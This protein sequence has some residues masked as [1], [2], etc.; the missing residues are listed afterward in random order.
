MKIK[1]IQLHPFAGIQEEKINF[2]DGM[3]L[4]IGPNMAGKSTI[5]YAINHGLLTSSNLTSRQFDN[6]MAP[7][8]PVGGDVIRVTLKVYTVDPDSCFQ[9]QK[10]WKPGLRNGQ[11]KLIKPDGT[12]I[13]DEDKIQKLIESLLPVTPSTMREVMLS[14]QSELHRLM[15][16]MEEHAE[17][18]QELSDVLRQNVMEAGGMSVDKFR[19]K[20]ES[21]YGDYFG[22]WDREK[23]YPED[24]N[25]QD[26]GIQYPWKQGVGKVLA[27]WYSKEKAKEWYDGIVAYE[28]NLDERNAALEEINSALSEKEEKYTEFN[29]IREGVRQRETLEARLESNKVKLKGVTEISTNWPVYEDRITNNAPQLAAL[30]EQLETLNEEQEKAS[31]KAEVESLK[32]RVEKLSKL[33]ERIKQAKQDV[34]EAKKVTQDDIDELRK[35]KSSIR[36][37]RT[38]I[39]ASKLKLSLTA[40]RDTEITISDATGENKTHTLEEGNKITEEEEGFVSLET[41]ELQ[42]TV[43]SATDNL[44]S[45]LVELEEKEKLFKSTLEK[46]EV[47]SLEDAVSQNQLYDNYKRQLKQ[48]N[49]QFNEELGDDEYEKLYQSLNEAGDVAGV[50]E[51]NIIQKERDQVQDQ[52]R[53]LRSEL[54]DMQEKI[55]GW[56][57]E[58]D[59]DKGKVLDKR[60]DL[61]QS[62]KEI[63]G[64]LEELPELPDKFDSVQEFNTFLNT[65]ARKI[66]KLQEQKA[67]T[68]EQLA[69]LAGGAPEQTS[70]DYQEVVKEQTGHFER[71]NKKAKSIARVYEETNSILEGLEEETYQ[72]LVATF[73]KW[74]AE[75]SD[76][77]FKTV[78]QESELPNAFV[79]SDNKSLPFDR[80]SHGT[81]D[82]AALAWKLTAAEYFLSDHS[83]FILL[84]DPMVDMD[85]DRRKQ[86]AKAMQQF[87]E[88]HQVLIFTCHPYYKEVIEEE[89][90]IELNAMA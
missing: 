41:H 88:A 81:K 79:T 73:T 78:E 18:Q 71:V 22:R 80:L 46:L 1:S 67:D 43:K 62:K 35:L 59:G 48:A 3:N 26:R 37:L 55:D 17:V 29:P 86:A 90:L 15:E 9:I 38:T 83:S 34:E 45:V 44:D 51:L 82:L 21:G 27:A 87:A 31:K 12:E 84:D 50:R 53:D 52:R 63:E 72:P 77:R 89:N 60:S 57:E 33:E 2:S 66:E 40:I 54:A 32:K 61:R 74:L 85:A 64:S 5:F 10:T 56:E 7:F 16:K 19:D 28:K 24:D 68:R 20:V 23:K 11:A 69:E 76:G 75:M 30:N 13:T 25:G 39:R 36:D 8:L 65:I 70:D 42:L 47:K 6:T 4:L 14:R 49:Q 58:F